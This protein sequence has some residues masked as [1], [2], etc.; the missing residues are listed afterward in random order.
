MPQARTDDKSTLVQ[1]MAWCHQATSHYLNQCWPRS[2]TPYGV[3]RPQWVNSLALARC[4]NNFETIIFELI[5]QNL[6]LTVELFTSECYTQN[7]INEKS[8]S[9]QWMACCCCQ[10]PSH[11][12]TQ[13]WS[14][15]MFP[16]G[17][18][19]QQW[20][21]QVGLH[22]IAQFHTNPISLSVYA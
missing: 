7:I 1:V 21:E 10:A 4:P 15:S 13:C 18:T 6:A 22:S 17:I 19:R 5:T 12:M 16:Y 14:W 9:L 20:V 8:T 11:Y 2:P 3:T